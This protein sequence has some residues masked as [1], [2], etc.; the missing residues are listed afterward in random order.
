MD[1]VDRMKAWAEAWSKTSETEQ[2]LADGALEITRLRTE[3]KAL[4]S[5]LREYGTHERICSINDGG[6][7]CD[8]GWSTVYT[9]IENEES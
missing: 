4:R 5:T 9:A 8:C 6:H 7:Y 2:L 3:N 1:I